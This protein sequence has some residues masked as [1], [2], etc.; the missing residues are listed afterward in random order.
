[1]TSDWP[2]SS[3]GYYHATNSFYESVALC[4]PASNTNVNK[5]NLEFLCDSANRMCGSDM[6]CTVDK[7]LKDNDALGPYSF[8]PK[9][10]ASVLVN[11]SSGNTAWSGYGGHIAT[12]QYSNCNAYCDS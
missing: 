9:E 12:G 4:G 11:I 6:S 10:R 3:W 1:M 5:A 7:I 8:C 2:Y